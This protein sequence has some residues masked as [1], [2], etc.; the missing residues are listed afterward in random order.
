[1]HGDTIFTRK[2]KFYTPFQMNAI[3]EATGVIGTFNDA[4]AVPAVIASGV[5]MGG[6][7]MAASDL[8]TGMI[9]CPMDLDPN[10]PVGFRVH[11]S[12]D[13]D[14]SG[15]A[16][17]SWIL[18]Q[19]AVVE[20]G[21]IATPTAALDT[22]IALLD[23]YSTTAGDTATTTDALYQVTGRGIRNSIGL[24]RSQVVNGALITISLELDAVANFTSV[25]FLFLEM[26]YVARRTQASPALVDPGDIADM[27]R[28]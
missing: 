16:T 21:A 27:D 11:Y 19:G 17:T 4:A 14:G 9:P 3:L 24:T 20:G 1:M 10:F 28:S 12:G 15:S 23:A 18:L 26:D 7:L 13:H 2:A 6:F 8:I 22:V 25:N 5:G